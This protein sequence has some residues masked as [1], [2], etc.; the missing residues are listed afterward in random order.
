MS[1]FRNNLERVEEDILEE[2][3]EGSEEEEEDDEERV[4]EE[5]EGQGRRQG[6]LGMV[7]QKSWQVYRAMFGA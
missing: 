3:H 7:R 2:D 6:W 1:S 5:E 4:G